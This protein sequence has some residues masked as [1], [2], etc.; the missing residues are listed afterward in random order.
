MRSVSGTSPQSATA[1]AS[2]ASIVSRRRTSGSADGSGVSTTC[3]ADMIQSYDKPLT[4]IEQ[5]SM[6]SGAPAIALGSAATAA[7]ERKEQAVG[8]RQPSRHG[9]QLRVD[10]GVHDARPRVA[11]LGSRSG[12]WFGTAGSASNCSSLGLGMSECSLGYDPL[13]GLTGDLGNQVE[14]RVVVQHGELFDLGRAAIRR[15]GTPTARWCPRSISQRWTSRARASDPYG[16]GTRRSW[17]TSFCGVSGSPRSNG[18]RSPSRVRWAEVLEGRRS[19]LFLRLQARGHRR[20]VACNDSPS[21]SPRRL[22]EG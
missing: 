21:F 3:S 16:R 2:S 19:G 9:A 17:S 14:V 4:K 5:S 1:A 7:V 11:F 12:G 18:S 15:S 8:A 20:A 10:R 6:A 22:F 13:A